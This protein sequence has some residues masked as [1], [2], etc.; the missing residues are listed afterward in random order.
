MQ[1]SS[2]RSWFQIGDKNYYSGILFAVHRL[3]GLMMVAL[4]LLHLYAFN[5]SL[6]LGY[7]YYKIF[8]IIALFHGMNG[9]RLS[10]QELGFFYN[11]RKIISSTVLAFWLIGSILILTFF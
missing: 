1:V 9:I 10:L 11:A 2:L 5:V 7:N 4:L 3:T 8:F 6:L